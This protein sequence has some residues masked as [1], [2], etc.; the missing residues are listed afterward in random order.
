[1]QNLIRWNYINNTSIDILNWSKIEYDITVTLC[2]LTVWKILLTITFQLP[3]IAEIVVTSTPSNCHIVNWL[4][5]FHILYFFL[6]ATS[7]FSHFSTCFLSFRHHLFSFFLKNRILLSKYFFDVVLPLSHFLISYLILYLLKQKSDISWC[8]NT[9]K[10][11][12]IFC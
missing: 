11:S 5:I 8:I 6:R 12:V 10:Y 1:M 4:P 9:C 7:I 3:S 2:W